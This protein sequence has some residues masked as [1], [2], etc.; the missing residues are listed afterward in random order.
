VSDTTTSK[1]SGEC[2]GNSC[3][4]WYIALHWL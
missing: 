3:C 4:G 1:L 2:G